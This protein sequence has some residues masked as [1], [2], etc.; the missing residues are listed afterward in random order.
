[1]LRLKKCVFRLYLTLYEGKRLFLISVFNVV[2]LEGP[3]KQQKKPFLY[4]FFYQQQNFLL[5]MKPFCLRLFTF[6]DAV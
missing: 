1:M 6:S 2:F 4:M 3:K 5:I